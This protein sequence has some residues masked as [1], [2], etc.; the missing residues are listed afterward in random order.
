MSRRCMITGKRPNAANNVSH[1]HNKT[2]RRQ[3]PN[4]QWK[5][6]FVPELNRSIRLRLSTTALRS[7][8]KTGF[9]P[10]LKKNGLTLKDVT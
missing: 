8:N 10:Y 7:I 5:S 3:Y 9:F 2:K 6:V 4:L 1:A